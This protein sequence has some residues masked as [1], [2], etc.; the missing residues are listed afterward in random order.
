[1]AVLLSLCYR[2]KQYSRL[3]LS[4]HNALGEWNPKADLHKVD[5]APKHVCV[6]LSIF[7]LCTLRTLLHYWLL[8]SKSEY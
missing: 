4:L 2:G 6:P 8:H 5:K 7:C 1:M 3:L